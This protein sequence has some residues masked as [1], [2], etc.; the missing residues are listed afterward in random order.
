[1]SKREINSPLYSV[2]DAARYLHTDISLV[3]KA[4]KLGYLP[5]FDFG[6]A[7]VY[8]PE[9]DK[10]ILKYMGAGKGEKL[11]KMIESGEQCKETTSNDDERRIFI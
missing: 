10:F 4:I 11:Q 1:M 5:V 6:S 2:V 8:R 3:R 9:M 7:K